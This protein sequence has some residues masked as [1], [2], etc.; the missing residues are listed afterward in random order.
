MWQ[1]KSLEVTDTDSKRLRIEVLVRISKKKNPRQ[2]AKVRAESKGVADV[3]V[4]DK[5]EK[6]SDSVDVWQIRT[7][8]VRAGC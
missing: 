3:L 7:L 8:E 6:L 2:S 4:S 1:T 5:V